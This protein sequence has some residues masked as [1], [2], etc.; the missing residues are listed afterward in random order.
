MRLR[1]HHGFLNP[2][3]G[4][5]EIEPTRSAIARHVEALFPGM[6][7][8][9]HPELL[10]FTRPLGQPDGVLQVNVHGFGPFGVISR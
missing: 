7:G 8:K 9:V 2:P 10:T 3:D 6:A 1:W 4:E 5:V